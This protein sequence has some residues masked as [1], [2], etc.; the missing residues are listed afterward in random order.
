[1]AKVTVEASKDDKVVVLSIK[2]WALISGLLANFAQTMDLFAVKERSE[3][4]GNIKDLLHRLA[5][6]LRPQGQ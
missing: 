4:I 3:A 2:E 6:A 1:M 5:E